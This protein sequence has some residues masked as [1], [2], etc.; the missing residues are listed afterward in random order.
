MPKG[1]LKQT[2][3]TLL[4]ATAERFYLMESNTEIWYKTKSRLPISYE[5][6]E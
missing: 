4:K 1:S 2:N 5:K 6:N 3:K